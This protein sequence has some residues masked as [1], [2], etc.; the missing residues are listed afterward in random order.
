VKVRPEISKTLRGIAFLLL[1]APGCTP[2]RLAPPPLPKAPPQPAPLVSA[3]ALQRVVPRLPAEYERVLFLQRP[4]RV[5]YHIRR[6]GTLAA[7]FS[8]RDLSGQDPALKDVF[9][10]ATRRVQG[11]PAV[12]TSMGGGVAVLVADRFRV[13]VVSLSPSVGGKRRDTWLGAVDYPRLR[14]LG[15]PAKK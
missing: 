12:L 13:E 10:S 7:T 6:A 1:A 4:G 9:R 5:T 14:A 11:Y 15:A 2:R 8:V 3:N